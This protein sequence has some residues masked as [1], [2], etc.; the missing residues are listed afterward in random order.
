MIVNRL[1]IPEGNK[2]EFELNT[3]IN[4]MSLKKGSSIT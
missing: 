1:I 2:L 4:Y 3:M